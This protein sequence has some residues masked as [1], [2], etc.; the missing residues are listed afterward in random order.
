M[1]V[2]RRSSRE[3]GKWLLRQSE[4]ERRGTRCSHVK[5]ISRSRAEEIFGPVGH[6]LS[7]SRTK[8]HAGA[9]RGNNT[10]YG[11]V[12]AAGPDARHPPRS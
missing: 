3:L 8:P 7:R 6:C 5:T 10:D 4:K 2:G 1:D 12:P 11:L 9:S